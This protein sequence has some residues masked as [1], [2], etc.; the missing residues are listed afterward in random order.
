MQH[1]HACDRS[2]QVR[3]RDCCQ[4]ERISINVKETLKRKIE[5][6]AGNKHCDRHH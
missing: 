5:R 6:V 2:E 4:R 3:R 1:R